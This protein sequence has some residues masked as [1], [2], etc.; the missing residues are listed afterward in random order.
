MKRIRTAL[1][2]GL[3]AAAVSALSVMEVEAHS[4]TKVSY[5]NHIR[6]VKQVNVSHHTGM[7]LVTETRTNLR[8]GRRV[9][10][11]MKIDPW[12]HV[13]KKRRLVKVGRPG[14]RMR[15]HAA[16]PRPWH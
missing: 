16:R 15:R 8:T 7:K 3:V 5:R 1:L 2:V 13:I 9:I 14:N 4:K 6:I 10:V 11:K 12:G